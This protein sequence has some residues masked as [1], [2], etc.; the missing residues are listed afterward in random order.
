MER[1]SWFEQGARNAD[2]DAPKVV[3]CVLEPPH[4]DVAEH[5]FNVLVCPRAGITCALFQSLKWVRVLAP[6][7]RRFLLR[8]S[9]PSHASCD[10]AAA[11][12]SLEQAQKCCIFSGS[13]A[14]DSTRASVFSSLIKDVP[15]YWIAPGFHRSQ[16][17]CGC[18]CNLQSAD[19]VKMP[20]P[21]SLLCPAIHCQCE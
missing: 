3:T 13:M 1:D 6:T 7:G 14:K 18:S 8:T 17:F 10:S 9:T 5:D 4:P 16:T 12:T 15:P 2:R 20:I 11:L 21:Q 19:R